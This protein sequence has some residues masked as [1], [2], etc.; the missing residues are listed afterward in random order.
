[1]SAAPWIISIV[2]AVVLTWSLWRARRL[3]YLRAYGKFAAA[4]YAAA[5]PLVDDDE[6]PEAVLETIDW[7]HVKIR[8]RDSRAA[9]MIVEAL[10][11]PSPDQAS[12]DELRASMKAF[13]ARRKELER[14]FVNALASGI[15]AITYCNLIFGFLARR[16][17]GVMTHHY[18]IAPLVMGDIRGKM[19]HP[20]R[21]LPQPA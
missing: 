21:H 19:N 11:G 9:R 14:P 6:T 8:D 15:L 4:F 10:T 2:G 1:M 7:L 20:D 18:E 3:L 16:M 12:G 17:L 13:F 5:Q